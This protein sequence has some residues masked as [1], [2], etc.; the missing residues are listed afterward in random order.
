MRFKISYKRDFLGGPVV[1]APTPNAGGPGSIPGQELRSYTLPGPN[2]HHNK[3]NPLK[4]HTKY[5]IAH[6]NKCK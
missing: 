3:I 6:E 1:T 4:A 2:P 5:V